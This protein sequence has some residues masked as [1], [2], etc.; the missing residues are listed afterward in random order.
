MI[1]SPAGIGTKNGS[2][3]EDHQYFTPPTDRKLGKFFPEFLFNFNYILS[4]VELG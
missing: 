3:G 2:T 4:F 1:L